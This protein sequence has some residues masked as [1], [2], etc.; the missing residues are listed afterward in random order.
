MIH[1]ACNYLP[2]EYQKGL[3]NSVG[4]DNSNQKLS[5][6]LTQAP[7]YYDLMDHTFN[8]ENKYYTRLAYLYYVRDSALFVAIIINLYIFVTFEIE[9]E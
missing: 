7:R 9:V 4:R 8:L 3:M 5:D 6:F 1:P 2:V